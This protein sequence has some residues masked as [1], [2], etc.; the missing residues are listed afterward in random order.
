M[1]RKQG[2][3]DLPVLIHVTAFHFLCEFEQAC[4]VRVDAT[5][6]LESSEVILLPLSTC[7]MQLA[8]M[9]LPTSRNGNGH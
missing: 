4:R 6:R 9:T 8:D 5:M 1:Q 2:L 3:P 7:E